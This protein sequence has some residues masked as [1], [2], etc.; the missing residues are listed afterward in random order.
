MRKLYLIISLLFTTASFGQNTQDVANFTVTISP[1][2]MVLFNNTSVVSDTQIKKAWWFFGDGVRVRTPALAGQSHQYVAGVYIA[3]LK[4][5]KY[6]PGTTDSVVTG[7]KCLTIT[8]GAVTIADS[9]RVNFGIRDTLNPL[10]RLFKA[11]PWHSN[12]GAIEKICWNFGDNK[13]TCVFPTSSNLNLNVL[14]QYNTTG[15]YNVCVKVWYSGGCT[16]TLCKPVIVSSSNTI[17]DSCKADFTIDP[18]VAM[19]M[20]RKFNAVHWSINQKRPVKVCWIFGNGRDTCITYPVSYTGPYN[21]TYIYPQ[22]GTYN[23]CSKI[24]YEGG[25]VAQK[26]KPV[27]IGQSTV[28]SCYISLN[29]TLTPNPSA[30]YRTFFVSTTP[31]RRP[32]QIKWIFGDGKDT[33][34]NLPNPVSAQSLSMSHLYPHHGP[35]RL[36]VRVVF[37]GGCVRERCID[38]FIPSPPTTLCGVQFRD[39]SVTSNTKIFTAIGSA[40]AADSILS[41]KWMFGDGTSAMGQQVTKR[42]LYGG[43]YEVCVT[44]RTSN[45][46]ERRV[47]RRIPVA[48]PNLPVL[49]LAPNPVYT[50]LNVIFQSNRTETVSVRIYNSMGTLVRSHTQNVVQGANGWT[51]NVSP[52]VAGAYSVVVQSPNQFANAI[53]F[54]R[55]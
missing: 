38:I 9:C 42:Y 31:S 12:Q 36:C 25:C 33:T 10:T 2:G 3:C 43:Y 50:T 28:D 35:Y 4:I 29:E 15:T 54:K 39:S 45:G 11:E 55:N 8:I 41:Y 49:Q 24:Y 26:C 21:V 14:H 16:A 46:C 18:M 7:E 22:A 44:M 51:Y 47:C 5:Y 52:L 53:F 13:D 34:V 6:I 17:I 32:E 37:A 27:I 1:S 30:L 20:G 40:P 48:G 23:V 19:P